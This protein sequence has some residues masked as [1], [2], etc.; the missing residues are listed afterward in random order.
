MGLPTVL[1]VDDTKLLLEIEKSFLENSPVRVLTAL[2]GEEASK[3]VSGGGLSGSTRRQFTNRLLP[4]G[5]GVEFLETTGEG[6]P[7]L[8]K[9]ELYE[10]IESH[11]KRGEE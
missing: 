2:N 6:L 1:L 10:F 4:P 9:T 5:F 11:R 3:I 7:I 8:R